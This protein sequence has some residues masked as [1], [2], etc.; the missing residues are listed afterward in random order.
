MQTNS[1]NLAGAR[2]GILI[3]ALITALIHL[4]L[5][6]VQGSFDVMFT[7]NGLGYLVLLAALFLNLPFARENRRW[8]RLGFIGFTVVTIVAW[9]LLG[10]KGWWLGWLDKIVEVALIALLLRLRP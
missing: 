1:E 8:V 3:L 6:F 9:V 7:L 5:N 2:L 10:D 4:S